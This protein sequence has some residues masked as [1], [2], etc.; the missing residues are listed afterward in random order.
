MRSMGN[1]AAAMVAPVRKGA[2]TTPRHQPRKDS[3]TVA[4][5]PPKK[6]K[7]VGW[8][9]LPQ[10]CR[11]EGPGRELR[12][13]RSKP[14]HPHPP[15]IGSNNQGVGI[16]N[17]CPVATAPAPHCPARTHVSAPCLTEIEGWG[18]FG[19]FFSPSPPPSLDFQNIAK[20]RYFFI[21]KV[22]AK[23]KK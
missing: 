17:G 9:T 5:G 4:K 1:A 11:R 12:D 22:K 7:K 23:F 20:P 15:G 3:K 18:A 6:K 19:T 8:L 13:H 21:S 16:L 10:P 2:H 14:M